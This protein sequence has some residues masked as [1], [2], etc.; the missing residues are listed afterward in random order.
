MPVPFFTCLADPSVLRGIGIKY[1]M[2]LSGKSE[3]IGG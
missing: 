2:D 3:F 1:E